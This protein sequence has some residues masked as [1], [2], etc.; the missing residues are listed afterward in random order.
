[1]ITLAREALGWTQKD[2]AAAANITQGHLSKLESGLVGAGPG[3]LEQLANALHCPVA[4][5]EYNA[6]VR[7]VEVTCLHHRRKAS[8]MGS[9]TKKRIEA[10]AQLTRISVDGLLNGVDLENVRNLHRAVGSAE[11]DPE[12]AAADTRIALGLLAGPVEN[13][14]RA[15]E[16]AGIVVVQR[17]LGTASQDAVTT[18]P[19]DSAPMMI[20]NTGLAAD[21]LRFTI[22]HELGHLILHAIPGDNQ[23]AEADQFASAFLAPAADIRPD[24]IDLKTTEM[25]R[26]M[27][28][29]VKW[30]LSIAALIRRA[31][32]LQVIDESQYR[33]F[34]IK[35]SRLG[36]RTVE[37]GAATAEVPSLLSKVI[38]LRC[39]QQGLSNFELAKLAVMS[40]ESFSRYYLPVRKPHDENL[41][42]V[43]DDAQAT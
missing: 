9:N 13:L 41:R 29:K 12:Y 21:R 4:L 24:L 5:L 11:V 6:P 37:P 28:L 35:L 16:A 25:S 39:D 38:R 30:G 17:A 22:A 7:G 34:Q 15:V 23:E 1:M 20:V 31:R 36:W 18:W 32:D 26:L 33:D 27:K 40:E 14:M 8:T 42:L 10:L 2:L 43:M 3:T 19:V